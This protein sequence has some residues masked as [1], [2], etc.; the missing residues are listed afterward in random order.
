MNQGYYNNNYY[1]QP[2]QQQPMQPYG[3]PTVQ[4]NRAEL[5]LINGVDEARNYVVSPNKTVYLKDLNSNRLFEKRANERGMYEMKVYELKEINQDANSQYINKNELVDLE[6][7]FNSKLDKLS[8]LIQKSISG[9]NSAEK[10]DSIG[11]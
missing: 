3:I 9:Q 1:Q 4:F 10:H 5:V 8:D 11:G 2:Y 7:R 6:N